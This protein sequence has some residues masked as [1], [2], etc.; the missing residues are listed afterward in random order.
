MAASLNS[1][2]NFSLGTVC[3]FELQLGGKNKVGAGSEIHN[4]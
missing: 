4:C 3:Q 1:S 2:N